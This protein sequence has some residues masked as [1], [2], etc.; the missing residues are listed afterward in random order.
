MH[1]LISD[2]LN[3]LLQ[4]QAKGGTEMRKVDRIINGDDENYAVATQT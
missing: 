4:H 3:L 1:F 2:W